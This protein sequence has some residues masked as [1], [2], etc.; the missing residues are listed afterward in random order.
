MSNLWRSN[1]GG[2]H[3]AFRC[4]TEKRKR[5]VDDRFCVWCGVIVPRQA[6]R[7]QSTFGRFYSYIYLRLVPFYF[8][9]SLFLQLFVLTFNAVVR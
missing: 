9:T 7:K 6:Q 2:R 5:D 3:S 1:R 4:T 8:V